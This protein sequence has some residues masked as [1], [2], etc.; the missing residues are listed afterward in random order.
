MSDPY[1]THRRRSLGLA[2]SA[3]G[4]AIAL[5]VALRIWEFLGVDGGW[6]MY[7]PYTTESSTP[8]SVRV[9]EILSLCGTAAWWIAAA[10]AL[11]NLSVLNAGART[12]GLSACPRCAYDSANPRGST[13]PECGSSLLGPA[14]S[15]RSRESS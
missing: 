4:V 3:L 12:R 15:P 9:Y 14:S 2:V 8:P 11:W 13:C 10:A 6:T 1:D 7:S 5:S